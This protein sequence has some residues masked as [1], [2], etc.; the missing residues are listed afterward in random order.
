MGTMSIRENKRVSSD[1]KEPPKGPFLIEFMLVVLV[2]S[3]VSF[4]FFGCLT[5]VLLLCVELRFRCGRMIKHGYLFLITLVFLLP[6]DIRLASSRSHFGTSTQF[7]RI[8]R[9]HPAGHAAYHSILKRE[10][11]AYFLHMLNPPR[12]IISVDSTQKM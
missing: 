1:S 6:I 7:I 11:E 10:G 8:V 12:W 2:L 9:A 5:C 3:F 4:R